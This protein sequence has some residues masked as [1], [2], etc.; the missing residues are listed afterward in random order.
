MA[1][2]PHKADALSWI[3]KNDDKTYSI[4]DSS[5]NLSPADSLQLLRDLKS[6]GAMRV[7][8]ID[9]ETDSVHET[10]STLIIE[11]STLPDAR[12]KV[13]Q[14]DA[15][16]AKTTAFDPTRDTGQKYLMLHW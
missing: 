11:L 10:T 13:F 2:T 15:R 6:A 16:V 5:E 3:G 9:T 7:V 14:I 12:K 1:T 4:G 8:A